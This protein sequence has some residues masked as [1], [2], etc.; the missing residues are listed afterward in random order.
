MP[1]IR[2]TQIA[3]E[4]LTRRPPAAS[5]IGTG[6]YPVSLAPDGARARSWVAMY[7]VDGKAVMQTISPLPGCRMSTRPASSRATACGGGG[8]QTRSPRNDGLRKRE[9]T[10]TVAAVA[11]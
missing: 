5:S 10:N 11:I 7:R 4:K 3:A 2:L 6:S 1:T 8:R 9:A